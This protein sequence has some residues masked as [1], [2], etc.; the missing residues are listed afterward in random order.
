MQL[1]NTPFII[2]EDFKLTGQHDIGRIL[3]TSLYIGNIDI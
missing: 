3:D 2:V 1:Q